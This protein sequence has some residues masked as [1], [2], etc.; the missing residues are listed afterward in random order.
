MT[1]KDCGQAITLHTETPA[2]HLE[3]WD[4]IGIGCTGRG[5]W[6]EVLPHRPAAG[7]MI[8]GAVR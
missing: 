3:W 5:E 7:T 8:R 1:C 2:G 6:G 4:V